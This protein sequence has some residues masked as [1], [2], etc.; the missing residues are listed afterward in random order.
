LVEWSEAHHLRMV[1]LA[2]LDQPY[3]PGKSLLFARSYDRD[4]LDP[5]IMPPKKGS[6][7]DHSGRIRSQL[8]DTRFFQPLE[9]L[10]DGR[11]LNRSLSQKS[12]EHGQLSV[13]PGRRLGA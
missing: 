3:T 11:G 1:G 2:P 8:G 13:H 6:V 9:G 7:A 5:G 4:L 10:T 12:V